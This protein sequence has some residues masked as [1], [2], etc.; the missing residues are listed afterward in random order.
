MD[1]KKIII[2]NDN[3][4]K[5]KCVKEQKKRVE[6]N[7]WGLTNDELLHSYQLKNLLLDIDDSYINLLK[8]H[9][10]NKI[11]CYKQQDINKN[12]FNKLDF[13]SLEGVYKLLID[14]ELKC[15]YC[16]DEVYILYEKVRERKQWTLDRINNDIGHNNNN[17]LI[18]CLE[19]NLKRRRTNKDAFF[20]TKNMVIIKEKS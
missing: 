18:C 1:I 17:L 4:K 6:T 10:K 13:V 16:S 8:N 19:C 7:T 14:S 9:I 12:R 2:E 15:C 11:N 5:I 20:F 3:N